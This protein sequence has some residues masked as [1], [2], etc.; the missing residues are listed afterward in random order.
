[1]PL[2]QLIEANN[3]H[4]SACCVSNPRALRHDSAAWRR[5]SS[6]QKRSASLNARL[7][8]SESRGEFLNGASTGFI[9]EGNRC[10]LLEARPA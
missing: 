7:A 5:I 6:F 4:A 9:S 1:L 10:A 2:S 3:R 8:A